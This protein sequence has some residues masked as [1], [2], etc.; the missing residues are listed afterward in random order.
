[1]HAAKG[2]EW[3]RV[4]LMAVNNYSFPSAQPADSY[5]AEKW[6]IRDQLNIQAE[7]QEQAEALMEG[8]AAGY[9]EGE[10]S[11][12]A[13]LEYAAERLRLLYV[14]IT[15][16]RRDLIITWNM[17]RFWDQGRRNTG[18]APLIALTAFWKKELNS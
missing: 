8:R 4:Y 16:A 11:R 14:G 13:R 7:A 6:F 12:A 9:V 1:M 5:I 2:L 3:D 18:A 10:A 15:R 17:G